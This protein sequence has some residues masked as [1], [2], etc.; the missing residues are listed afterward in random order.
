MLEARLEQE[1]EVLETRLEQELEVLEELWSGRLLRQKIQ[2]GSVEFW[3]VLEIVEWVGVMFFGKQTGLELLGLWGQWFRYLY[4]IVQVACLERL[5]DGYWHSATKNKN[6]TS[7]WV[8]F[9][10]FCL[11]F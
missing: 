7:G 6:G 5:L 8:C 2:G 11:R 1:L 9:D 3:M 10:K 4:R